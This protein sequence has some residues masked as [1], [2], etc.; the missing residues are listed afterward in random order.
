MLNNK[1]YLSDVLVGAGLGM[2]SAKLAYAIYHPKTTDKK[3]KLSL[4]FLPSHVLGKNGFT[5]SATF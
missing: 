2:L 1:H 5:L 4:N 3:D